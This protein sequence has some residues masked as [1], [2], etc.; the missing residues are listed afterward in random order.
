MNQR[1]Y[2]S[3]IRTAFTTGFKMRL[4]VYADQP[5]DRSANQ[6][7][8]I[9]PVTTPESASPC[10]V[11]RSPTHDR[12]LRKWR[13]PRRRHGLRLEIHFA[14]SLALLVPLYAE[15]KAV[16][17]IRA[18][19]DDEPREFDAEDERLMLSLGRFVSSAF[20]GRGQNHGMERLVVSEGLFPGSTTSLMNSQILNRDPRSIEG[21]STMFKSAQS[22]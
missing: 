9:D 7:N 2:G 16:G 18:V 15:G 13:G 20:P 3:R 11:K 14:R 21:A 10:R 5:R 1:S 22:S 19:A 8:F 4:H 6:Q 12:D 17:T